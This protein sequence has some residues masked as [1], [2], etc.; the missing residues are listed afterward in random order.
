MLRAGAIASGLL[1]LSSTPLALAQ[2]QTALEFLNG[3][4]LLNLSNQDQFAA[5]SYVTGVVDSSLAAG[6]MGIGASYGHATI[7]LPA[8][9]T[10]AGLYSVVIQYLTNHN[11]AQ[12]L[13]AAAAVAIALRQT[14][15]CS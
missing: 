4:D 6:M 8:H 11:D 3:S 10:Q 9:A 7:C 13:P 14:Y 12:Q 2:S 5:Q 1:F 15:P